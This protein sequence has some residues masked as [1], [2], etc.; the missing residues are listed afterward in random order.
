MKKI[1]FKPSKGYKYLEDVE[2][3]TLVRA[4]LQEAVYLESSSGS[5]TVIVLEYKGSK[6]DAPFYLGKRSWANK[7]EVKEVT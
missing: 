7:T 5:S 1:K 2:P 3:G 4:G 6:E